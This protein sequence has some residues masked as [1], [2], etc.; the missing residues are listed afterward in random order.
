MSEPTRIGSVR[1]VLGATVT[2]ELASSLAGTAPVWEGRLQPVGQIGSIVRIPQGP[3]TLLGTVTMVGISELAGPLAPAE[4]ASLGN[5]WLKVQLV[6]EIDGIGVFHRGITT[7]PSLDDGVHFATRV[8]LTRVFP[9]SDDKRVRFGSVS[10]TADVPVSLDAARM[11]NRHAAIVGSTGAGKTSA[12][13][14]LLQNFMRGGWAR[15]NIIVIDPHGEYSDALQEFA[16][17]RSVIA[18]DLAERLNVPYWTLPSA[19][20]FKAVGGS[21]DSSITTLHFMDII[22]QE[23][24]RFAAACPWLAALD[25]TSI[26]ADTPIPFDLRDVWFQLETDNRATFNAKDNTSPCIRNEGDRAAII[27]PGYDPPNPGGAAPFRGRFYGQFGSLPE[28][29]RIRMRDPRLKFFFDFE[30][31]ATDHDV[32]ATALDSWLGSDK[33]IAVMDFSGVPGDVADLAIGAVLQNIFEVA[34]RSSETGIGRP[35]PVLVILEEAHR[36]LGEG[37]QV[38]LARE[39]AN[40]IAREGRKYGVGLLLVSQR[41]SE[42]PATA[43]SQVGTIIALRLTNGTDQPTVKS[44]LPDGVAGLADALPSLRNGEAIVSGESVSFP[45]RAIADI[46]NPK[47]NA[48]DPSLEPWRGDPPKHIEVGAALRLWRAIPEE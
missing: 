40:R 48:K 15:S 16:S 20:L 11:V 32:L 34:L 35:S 6:G 21:A 12:V 13:C 46:P 43:L 10:A 29:M 39:V 7:Y 45:T 42:L 22:R 3:T 25:R 41:P 44:A 47:P 23:K 18:P 37:D 36:Y 2:V 19:E 33:P 28:R 9:N 27:P 38:R 31:L 4:S 5:R 14:S 17:A 24:Q 26:T 30:S 1:H 8:D